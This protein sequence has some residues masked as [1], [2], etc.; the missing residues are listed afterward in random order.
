MTIFEVCFTKYLVLSFFGRR[1]TTNVF[2]VDS[3]L[4]TQHTIF[5]ITAEDGTIGPFKPW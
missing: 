2:Y 4:A 5:Y 3:E 1:S